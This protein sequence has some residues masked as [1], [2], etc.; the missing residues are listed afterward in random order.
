M[1]KTFQ[2]ALLLSV[3]FLNGC[4]TGTRNIALEVPTSIATDTT[5][6]SVYISAINDLRVFEQ[7]PK[8]PRTP[9]VKGKLDK[10]TIDERAKLIGRQRNGYGMAMG[11]VALE[12]GRTVQD[13][14]TALLTTALKNRGYKLS[15]SADGAIAISADI[16]KFWAWFVPGFVSISF[17][18][19]V[20]IK[21]NS[22]N[23]SSL[24]TGAGLNKGQIASNANWALTYQRAY[25]DFLND[26]D[27]ALA[28]LGL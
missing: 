12:E 14:T 10:T 25:Q 22:N 17:E 6:G 3:I 23:R 20:A 27:Q 9:S 28:D 13:E 16:E 2:L 4:V 21:L 11:S 7:K 5:K 8:S 19:E 1:K 15:D 26:V 24:V 18:S